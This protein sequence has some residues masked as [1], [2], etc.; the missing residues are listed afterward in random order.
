MKKKH[1]HQCPECFEE[2]PYTFKKDDPPMNGEAC[3]V[4]WRGL[5]LGGRSPADTSHEPQAKVHE[6]FRT[7]VGLGKQ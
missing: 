4:G 2:F 7:S 1:L 3:R 6:V 5:S